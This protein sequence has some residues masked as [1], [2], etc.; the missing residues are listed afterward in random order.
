MSTSSPESSTISVVVGS[1]GARGSVERCLAALEPQLT[2]GVDVL[3]CEPAASPAD[4]QARF[5]W[6]TFLAFPGLAVPYLW[7]EGID[8]ATGVTVALTISPMVPAPDWL[9]TIRSLRAAERVVAGAIES[10]P[11]L[12]LTDWAEYACRYAPDMLPFDGHECNALP[13]DNAAYEREL[14][15]RT[16]TL[17][18]DGFWEPI[19]HEQLAR[20]GI[21]LW[22]SPDL[23]V[24]QGRSAGTA[25]F[26]R[27][28]LIHG[29]GHGR[30]RGEGFSAARNIVGIVAS[31]L[32]PPLVTLRM[33]RAIFSR[34]RFR[35]RTLAALPYVLAFNVAWAIG[36]ARGH[37]DA[38]GSSTTTK[39]HAV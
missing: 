14:L 21:R 31:P 32:V 16:R 7:R 11:G 29:R 22:H 20:D 26:I 19:V 12:R 36:E 6:A 33:L 2:T 8:R 37:L 9:A 4:I 35:A 18:A 17:W 25:A 15:G 10:G 24:A 28:R 13:G 27:Q 1:N 5:P 39:H 34:R 30:T 23:V 38:L 3:V